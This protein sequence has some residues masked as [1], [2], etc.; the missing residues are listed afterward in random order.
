MLVDSRRWNLIDRSMTAS[1]LALSPNSLP[2]PSSHC[3]FQSCM[4]KFG[5]PFENTVSFKHIDIIFN[6]SK[7]D[8]EINKKKTP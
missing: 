8:K 4:G 1:P 6:I 2:P 3:T 7:I 5:A